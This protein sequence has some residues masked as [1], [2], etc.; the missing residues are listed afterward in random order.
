M[1]LERPLYTLYAPLPTMRMRGKLLPASFLSCPLSA[2]GFAPLI[3]QVANALLPGMLF[4]SATMLANPSRS[5]TGIVAAILC[6]L[7]API[8]LG[9]PLLLLVLHLRVRLRPGA[10]PERALASASPCPPSSLHWS[11]WL[12]PRVIY[13]HTLPPEGTSGLRSANGMAIDPLYKYACIFLG[14]LCD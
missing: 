6:L 7:G 8:V 1:V 10:D 5:M 3:L 14:Q 13:G 2:V 11:S 9:T 12:F 4:C